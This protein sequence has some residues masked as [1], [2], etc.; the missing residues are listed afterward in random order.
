[1]V[2]EV[3]ER[4]AVDSGERV[5]VASQWQLMW[6]RFRK[7]RLAIVSGFVIIGFYLAVLQEGEVGTGDPIE[8]LGR[9]ENQVTVTE[10]ARLYASGSHSSDDLADL[11][12]AV[13]LPALPENWR[14]RFRERISRTE[15]GSPRPE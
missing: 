9:D 14:A 4:K 5:Y 11:R 13:Q 6:W 3:V 1:V 8:V 7:H 2:E 15:S 10:I 12:R